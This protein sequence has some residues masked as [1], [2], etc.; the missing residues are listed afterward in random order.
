MSEMNLDNLDS[1][2]ITLQNYIYRNDYLKA[3][4]ILNEFKE[5]FN[6][7]ESQLIKFEVFNKMKMKMT[8]KILKRILKI[9]QSLW[10]MY[11]EYSFL[12]QKQRILTNSEEKAIKKNSN[13]LRL[14]FRETVL[15]F[16]ATGYFYIIQNELD[17]SE[18]EFD[19]AFKIDSKSLK[20]M[21]GFLCV[22][23]E[24]RDSQ[25]QYYWINEILKLKKFH[26]EALKQKC[27]LLFAEKSYDQ[28]L[29]TIEFIYEHCVPNDQIKKLEADCYFYKDNFTKARKAYLDLFQVSIKNLK[30]EIMIAKTY[31]I[32][33]LFFKVKFYLKII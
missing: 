18:S 7:M 3:W 8:N 15:D 13:H 5:M 17:K 23:K 4:K 32:Q 22:N 31:Y 19:N 20:V 9:D 25:K 30:I 10:S 2:K 29:E 12:K 33:N 21:F 6:D 24:K 28:C 26:F 16:C 1:L 14:A 11:L 27:F